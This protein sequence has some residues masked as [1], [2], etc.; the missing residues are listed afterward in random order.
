M[1]T[2]IEEKAIALF[3][4]SFGVDR[5][6]RF[7]KVR[8]E[9]DECSDALEQHLIIPSFGKAK[10]NEEHLKDEISD[11]YATVTHFASLFGLFHDELLEMAVDKVI[12]RKTNKNYK[13]Y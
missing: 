4:H 12:K 6:S 9:M 13:R 5:L 7:R 8:E 10:E 1:K 2:E 11:L 3:D